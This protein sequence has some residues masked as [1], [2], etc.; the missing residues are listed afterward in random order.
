MQ[1]GYLVG[2]RPIL[3]ETSLLLVKLWVYGI[4]HPIQQ[5]SIKHFSRNGQQCYTSVIEAG[6]EITFLGS[7]VR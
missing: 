5:D 7:L 2:A 3:T 4:F 6:D 1:R